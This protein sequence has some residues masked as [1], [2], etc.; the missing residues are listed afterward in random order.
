[1]I[2]KGAMVKLESIEQKHIDSQSQK[3]KIFDKGILE[4]TIHAFILLDRLSASGLD[5]IF[6]GGTSLLLHMTSPKRLSVDID[7]VCGVDRTEFDKILRS[8]VC[9]PP[10]TD[11][12]SQDRGAYRL[13]KRRHYKFKYSAKFGGQDNLYVLL[14]VVEEK[15]VIKNIIKKEVAHSFLLTDTKPNTVLVPTIDA[16][17]GDKLT[18]FAPNTIGIPLDENRSHQVFKQLFDV[19]QLFDHAADFEVIKNSYFSTAVAEAGYRGMAESQPA[20]ALHD[21]I[22]TA[23]DICCIDFPKRELDPALEKLLRRGIR[24]LDSDLINGV[25]FDH[26]AA[27]IAAARTAHIACLLL[28]NSGNADL[29]AAKFS[30][31]HELVSTLKKHVMT[32]NLRILDKMKHIPEAYWHWYKIDQ[33][34]VWQPK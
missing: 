28:D 13:P 11:F 26:T 19:A 20:V 10:F 1:M 17:L 15:N 14:D 7:I 29:Q 27:K 23:F 4:R 30:L 6:K 21:T 31:T 3:L 24:Q 18:A 33:S 5:F 16:L 34:K 25:N 32:E 8:A 22:Q 2:L 9:H 12:E